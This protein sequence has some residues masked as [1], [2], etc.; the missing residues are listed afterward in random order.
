M[1]FYESNYW[2][3]G[4]QRTWASSLRYPAALWPCPE[5][6]CSCRAWAVP[7]PWYVN[8]LG[9]KYPVGLAAFTSKF[10]CLHNNSWRKCHVISV[11]KKTS[12][13]PWEARTVTT[14]V[15]A[16]PEIF[17][18]TDHGQYHFLYYLIDPYKFFKSPTIVTEIDVTPFIFKLLLL[19]T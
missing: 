5:L 17:V 7:V 1:T 11:G 14:F 6:A 15:S 4:L 13:R 12:P 19:L 3:N 10:L 16:S 2:M 9:V 8:C 18:T